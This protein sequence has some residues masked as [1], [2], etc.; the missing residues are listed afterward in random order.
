MHESVKTDSISTDIPV[1]SPPLKPF[2][3]IGLLGYKIFLQQQRQYIRETGR[4]QKHVQS[5]PRWKITVHVRVTGRII[6]LT[7][8]LVIELFDSVL[9]VQLGIRHEHHTANHGIAHALFSPPHGV[10]IPVI[11]FPFLYFPRR[12]HLRQQIIYLSASK[13]TAPAQHVQTTNS[14]FPLYPK[15]Q[16]AWSRINQTLLQQ[17]VHHPVRQTGLVCRY[18]FLESFLDFRWQLRVG[19]YINHHGRIIRNKRLFRDISIPLPLVHP[20]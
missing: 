10:R 12:K 8:A 18:L 15:R 4:I 11:V 14:L 3:Y 9:H 17:S 7:L 13:H 16:H 2:G 1:Q 20:P 5:R 19:I 6:F